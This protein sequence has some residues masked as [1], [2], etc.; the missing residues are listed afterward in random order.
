MKNTIQIRGARVNNL[1]DITVEIPKNKLVVITGLSGSGKSSLAFDTL[2]A[3]GQR[4][5]VES[6]GSFIRQFL[7]L[8]NKPDVDEIRGLS[9]TIA[10]D[11]KGLSEN[12]RSTVGTIT[13][14]ADYLRLLFSRIG[15]M[16][17]LAC[18]APLRRLA[19]EEI[20]RELTAEISNHSLILLAPLVSK[21]KTE[22]TADD[23][24]ERLERAGFSEVRLNGARMPLNTLK[25]LGL[26]QI[27]FALDVVIGTLGPKELAEDPGYVRLQI[28][29]ALELGDG[30]VAAEI[31]VPAPPPLVGGAR[32]GGKDEGILFFSRELTCPSCGKTYPPYEPRNFSFNSPHGACAGCTGLGVKATVIPELVLPNPRL[33]LRE[34]AIKPWSR[35]GAN[36]SSRLELLNAVAAKH[37]FSLDTPVGELTA[38]SRE[39]VLF[40]AKDE[41]YELKGAAMKF[42]GVI[43]E[44][45]SRYSDTDSDYIRKEI[46]TYMRQELCL[47]CQGGRLKPETLAV[48]L[49]G[50][51]IAELGA[52]SI[53]DA[54][55]FFEKIT[56]STGSLAPSELAVATPIVRE[57]LTRLKHLQHAGLGYLSL[58]RSAPSISGGEGQRIRLA[59]QLGTTLSGVIY[60]LDEPTVGLHE[61]DTQMLL[62]LLRELI[63]NENTVVV[64][65]HDARL[66]READF[67]IDMGPGAGQCGGQVVTRGTAGAI[68]K[69]GKSLTGAY[70]AGRKRIALPSPSPLPKGEGGRRPGEGRRGNGKALFIKG[71][72]AFNLKNVD[73]KIPLG[74]FV[75]VTGV[76]GSGKSTL[77]LEIL[78]KALARKLYNAHDLPAAHQEITGLQHLDKVITVDQ[79]PIGRTPRSNPATY[80][81]IFTLVRDLYTEI[82]ES[83][84]KGFD[85]GTFSFNV[86]GGR[87]ESCTGEGYVKVA[88]Q[89]M[90]DT[91]L[92]C[93]ECHGTRYHAHALEVH[94]KNKN[95]AEVLTLSAAEAKIFFKDVPLLAEK[96]Q[97]LE[98]VGLGYIKLGQGAPTLSGGEAQRVKLAT[99]LSRRAT[100]KT[101][102]ILDEPTTGLHFDDI[103]HLLLVLDRLVEKG[104]AV[105]V[106]EHNLEVI[107]CADWVIDMG[108]EGG[109]GGGYLVAEGTPKDICKVKKSYTG[110]YLK[111]VLSPLR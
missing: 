11:Q 95:I 67:I 85:A 79:T 21:N 9:P 99:E 70:L 101:L 1:K 22:E 14:I 73:V 94:Y 8:Q 108:P 38:R 36:Q 90:A 31:I 61:R 26:P 107:K 40:G 5:Y 78:G 6:L 81:G 87:C 29:T 62:N 3:E 43:P 91:Y 54:I 111:R 18:Q 28:L 103:Q 12:P 76:S 13:E 4:R 86:R 32:G 83:K 19:P 100:G 84:L 33:T 45:Q 109:K 104:N 106:I 64:V 66:M 55:E 34:G 7:E 56:K 98:D 15:K 53:D 57:I 60:V 51:N 37:K 47:E 39:I 41:L 69:H 42:Q 23:I 97:V 27:P 96:L 49:A 63:A 75:C 10:I 58:D 74:K 2:F 71:A 50:K 88:M 30:A 68:M 82:P 44:L 59:V 65:E 17:C 72:S 25:E 93:P 52:L 24:I 48:T 105:L 110:Q 20:V 35:I 16:E 89:F 80:T 77:I 102:Y 92:L 46:E